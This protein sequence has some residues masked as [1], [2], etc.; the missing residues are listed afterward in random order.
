MVRSSTRI[1]LV[2]L[3]AATLLACGGGDDEGGEDSRADAILALKGDAT[4]GATVYKDQGCTTCHGADG[5]GTSVT[6]ENVAAAAVSEKEE[7]IEQILNGG[8]L[9]TAYKDK[10]SDQQIADVVAYLA[11]LN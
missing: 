1:L 11:S 9:M 3:F 4:A 8:G 6:M 2:S 10:L 5:K 7:S